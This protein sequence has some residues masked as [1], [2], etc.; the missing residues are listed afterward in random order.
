MARRRKKKVAPVI[1][2]SVGALPDKLAARYSAGPLVFSD[3]SLRR[4]G[5]LAAVLFAD[6]KATP[7]IE[8][9][10]VPAMGSNQLELQ[11][12]LFGLQQG[13]Q[14]FPEQ[15]FTLFSD[16]QD[17]VIRLNRA[18]QDGLARDGEL[19][20]LLAGMAIEPVLGWATIAWVKGHGRCLGNAL[21]DR[22]AAEAAS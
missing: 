12:L 9:R 11:A 13:G 14:H 1:H 2:M 8:T 4:Q 3:A 19:A 7:R 22:H 20:A 17:G 5:G 15:S 6:G 10:S 16:N 18:K 21:A